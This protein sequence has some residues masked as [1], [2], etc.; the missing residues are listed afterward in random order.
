L[1]S[2]EPALGAPQQSHAPSQQS[3]GGGWHDALPKAGRLSAFVTALFRDGEGASLGRMLLGGAVVWA[4]YTLLY[5]FLNPVVLDEVLVPAQIIAGTVHYPAGHPHDIYYREA[6]SLSNYLAA[7]GLRLGLDALTISRARNAW[8]LFLSVYTAFAVALL[9]APQPRWAHVSS[10][11]TACNLAVPLGGAYPI[12]VP[13]AFWSHGHIGLHTALL[14]AVL[15]LAG[16]HRTGG[17]LLGLLPSVHAAM[18]LVLWPWGGAYLFAHRVRR[19]VIPLV[20]GLTACVLLAGVIWLHAPSSRVDPAYDH[21]LDGAAVLQT[22]ITYTDIHRQLPSLASLAY[23]PN[24]LAFLILGGLFLGSA[25]KPLAPPSRSVRAIGGWLLLLGAVSWTIV[26]VPWIAQRWLG[27]LPAWIWVWM[28]YRFS[29]VSAVLSLPLAGALLA[30]LYGRIGARARSVLMVM[31]IALLLVAGVQALMTTEWSSAMQPRDHLIVVVWG[32]VL[33][34]YLCEPGC[35][36]DRRLSTAR[37]AISG[38][39]LILGVSIFTA[40]GWRSTVEFGAA[41]ALAC[42]GLGIGREAGR[43]GAA[44]RGWRYF[45]DG[46]LALACVAVGLATLHNRYPDRAMGTAGMTIS[47]FDRELS[48]WLSKHARAHELILA[49]I[50]PVLELQAKTGHP[51]LVEAE[52]LWLMSYSRRLSGVIGAITRDV[53]GVDYSATSQIERLRRTGS[54]SDPIWLE[55]W[56]ARPRAAWPSLRQKYGIRLVLSATPLD[57]PVVLR[58]AEW[59]LYEIPEGVS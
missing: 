48:A 4:A 43:R 56:E 2:N 28:P 24:F 22:F 34:G 47:G 18:T 52:T 37:L 58:G 9:L 23:L 36:P 13:P 14:T 27:S 40:V 51:V 25:G 50:D 6:F 32:F 46:T 30:R 17:L 54:L 44:P 10:L 53:Y 11:L 49:P 1:S 39:T 45:L 59:I 15:L 16:Y 26:Y 55:T 19:A 33:G 57:L 7:G 20:F 31:T 35:V 12:F 5:G 42:A 38:A 3:P 8:F 21:P 29:N 41:V